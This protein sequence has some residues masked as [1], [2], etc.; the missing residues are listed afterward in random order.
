MG[1]RCLYNVQ[2]C[3]KCKYNSTSH[4]EYF[5]GVKTDN[6]FDKKNNPS[7]PVENK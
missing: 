4:S 2:K 6:D 7:Y 5:F 1:R 3:N